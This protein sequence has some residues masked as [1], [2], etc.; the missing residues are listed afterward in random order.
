MNKDEG[1]GMAAELESEQVLTTLTRMLQDV[2]GEDSGWAAS[3]TSA[4]RL[5]G[6]LRLES[7]EVTALAGLLAETYGERVDL[8]GFLAGLDIDQLI[9]LTVADVAAYVAGQPAGAVSGG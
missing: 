5:E 3:I 2:T 7:V 6:D 8:L 1:T 9:G 4:S